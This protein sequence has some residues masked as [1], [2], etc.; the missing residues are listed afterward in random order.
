VTIGKNAVVIPEV[1]V[2]EDVKEN[3]L[4]LRDKTIF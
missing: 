1:T 2:K 4:V 3:G